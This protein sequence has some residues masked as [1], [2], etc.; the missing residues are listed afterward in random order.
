VH[1]K[2]DSQRFFRFSCESV[3]RWG[4]RVTAMRENVYDGGPDS[5]VAVGAVSAYERAALSRGAAIR[6]L[7]F[8]LNAF[9]SI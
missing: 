4:G 5:P 3:R 1:L 2:T 7:E 6:Y 8:T 9:S